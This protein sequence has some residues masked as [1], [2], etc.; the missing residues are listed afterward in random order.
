MTEIGA[1]VLLAFYGW[2]WTGSPLDSLPVRLDTVEACA[3]AAKAFP[4]GGNRQWQFRC[5]DA[6]TGKVLATPEGR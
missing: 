6:R 2:P 1:V 5:I 3:E 4:A